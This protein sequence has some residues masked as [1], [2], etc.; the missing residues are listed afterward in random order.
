[1]SLKGKVIAITGGASGI[2]LA[3]ANLALSRGA[4]VH[5]A[6]QDASAIEAAR[7][8]LEGNFYTS[9]LDVTKVDEV[10]TWIDSIVAQEGHLDGA[11]NSA[12]VIGKKH[13]ITHLTELEDDEWFKIVGVNLTGLMFCLRAE[14]RKINDGGS[15]VNISS[16]QGVMGFPG[17]AAYAATKHGVIGLTRSTAKEVGSRSIRVNAVAPG[18]I[19]TPLLKR[20]QEANPD[21]GANN[22][23]AIKRH[24]TA[25][26]MASI[27]GFLLGDESSYV[28]G[29]VYGGD[30][31]WNC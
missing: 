29:A 14:L 12:G 5:I 16:I 18:A 15:I 8:E 26:E 13:G 4:T 25:E 11:V 30:G 7:K 17:S 21:E 22:P 9:V 6:D 27:I 20:A 1:M 28:T 2:G 24:G 10:N 23:T 3:T 19:T 31:G